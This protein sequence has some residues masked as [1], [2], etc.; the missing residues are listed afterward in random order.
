M[1]CEVCFKSL[2]MCLREEQAETIN[3]CTDRIFARYELTQT[4]RDKVSMSLCKYTNKTFKDHIVSYPL[5]T[6]K[7][8]DSKT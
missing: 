4:S 3:D 1:N 5:V 7:S 2:T 6:K 8:I